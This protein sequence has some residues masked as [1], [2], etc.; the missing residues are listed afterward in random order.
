MI[1]TIAILPN[2]TKFVDGFYYPTMPPG[3]S[4]IYANG[5]AY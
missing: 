2:L 3:I 5:S 1:I 4:A